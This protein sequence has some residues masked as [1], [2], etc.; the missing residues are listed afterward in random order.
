MWERQKAI[1]KN[2]KKTMGEMTMG[3]RKETTKKRTKIESLKE[4]IMIGRVRNEKE[5]K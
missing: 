3:I 2:K 1:R 4:G 5:K